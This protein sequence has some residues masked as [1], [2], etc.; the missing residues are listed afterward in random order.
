MEGEGKVRSPIRGGLNKRRR[1]WVCRDCFSEDLKEEKD[2]QERRIKATLPS[3]EH[4]V[5]T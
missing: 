5:L 2:K 3:S 4:T 1:A